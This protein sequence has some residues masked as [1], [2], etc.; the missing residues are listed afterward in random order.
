MSRKKDCGPFRFKRFAVEHSR[1]SMRVGVDAVLIGAWVACGAAEP[2]RILDVGCGCGVI[3]LMM[4]QRFA[5]A[6]VTAIDVDESSVEEATL[7][8]NNSAWADRLYCELKA[9][10]EVV[11]LVAAGG[12]APFDLVVSNPPFFDDGIAEPSTRREKARHQSELSPLTLV[13]NSRTLLG[14]NGILGLIAPASQ[15]EEIVSE[16]VGAGLRLSRGQMVKGSREANPKR[17]MLEF[18][19]VKAGGKYSGPGD[20]EFPVL[21]IENAPNTFTEE[22]KKLTSQFYINF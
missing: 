4:A 8:F 16:A 6:Q 5:S 18:V 14:E 22:Y 12:C 9:F 2:R 3:S 19:K 15:A 7:N 11:R 20:I 10:D 13:R 17:I 21:T 1:S